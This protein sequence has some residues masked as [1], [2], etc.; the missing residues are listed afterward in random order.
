M[1]SRTMEVSK[2]SMKLKLNL[3]I[4]MMEQDKVSESWTK[5]W[6][7]FLYLQYNNI[8]DTPYEEIG[9]YNVEENCKNIWTKEDK[10]RS[11]V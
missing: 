11:F 2:I 3:H 10:N 5:I 4:A 9:H 8:L 1:L 6:D 7:I